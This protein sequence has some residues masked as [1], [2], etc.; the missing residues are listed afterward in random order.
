MVDLKNAPVEETI[1]IRWNAYIRGLLSGNHSAGDITG[2][3]DQAFK[4]T[5][6]INASSK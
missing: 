1:Y 3:I 6:Q 5:P 4:Q 2:S